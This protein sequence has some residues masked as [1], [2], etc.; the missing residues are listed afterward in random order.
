MLDIGK[1]EKNMVKDF[2]DLQMV[3]LMKVFGNVVLK[4]EKDI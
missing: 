1:Q 2:L 4:R 3:L